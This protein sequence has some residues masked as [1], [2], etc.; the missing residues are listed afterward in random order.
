MGQLKK[1]SAQIAIGAIA[2]ELL[3]IVPAQAATPPPLKAEVNVV[4]LNQQHIGTVEFEKDGSFAT[5]EVTPGRIELTFAGKRF[6]SRDR[7]ERYLL[8]RAALLAKQNGASW[9]GLLYLPGEA[10]PDS[11]PARSSRPS[12][13]HYGHWQPHWNYYVS[14]LGWQPWHPEWGVAFWADSIDLSLVERYDAHAMIELGINRRPEEDKPIF[15]VDEVIR[16]LG[17]SFR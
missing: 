16:D 5:S 17:P 15:D 6:E 12:Q 2:A 10:G 4:A 8:Y 3:G 13:H 9:F 1:G 11:H 7:V 14:G